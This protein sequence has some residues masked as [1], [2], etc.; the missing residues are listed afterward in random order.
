MQRNTCFFTGH[1]VLSRDE[2]AFLRRKLPG[3]IE[4]LA[5]QGVKYFCSAGALGFDRL[6]EFAVLAV[7]EKRP[8]I[9]LYLALPC[10]TQDIKWTEYEKKEYEYIK[11]RADKVIY[12][13]EEY[14]K[15]CMLDGNRFLADRSGFCLCYR[16]RSYGGTAYAVRYAK[17][18][19]LVIVN[20]ARTNGES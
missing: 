4:K 19:G 6:C 7:R 1:R 5:D 12:T 18:R 14:Y 8:E 11:F 16:K 9:R 2:R 15:G 10:K 13:A 20:L 17:T 3:E